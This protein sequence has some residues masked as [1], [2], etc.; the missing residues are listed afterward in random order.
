MHSKAIK[1]PIARKGKYGVCYI[2]EKSIEGD[3]CGANVEQL[4]HCHIYTGEGLHR[5]AVD[6]RGYEI[7]IGEDV[8]VGGKGI[9]LALQH[10][11]RILT[12]LGNDALIYNSTLDLKYKDIAIKWRVHQITFIISYLLYL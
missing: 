7:D 11:S 8:A 3:L 12:R 4:L 5:Q 9:D 6:E 1:Q 2:K 10:Y